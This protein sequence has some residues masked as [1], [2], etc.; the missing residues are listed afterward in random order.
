VKKPF[1]FIIRRAFLGHGIVFLL[2]ACSV[3]GLLLLNHFHDPLNAPRPSFS[4]TRLD[5]PG[6]GSQ[7]QP[8]LPDGGLSPAPTNFR[9]RMQGGKATHHSVISLVSSCA[10]RP[11]ILWLLGWVLSAWGCSRIC[12]GRPPGLGVWLLFGFDVM[13][14]EGF[15]KPFSPRMPIS[16]IFRLPR[17]FFFP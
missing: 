17:L 13:P 5:A 11:R 6:R 2:I 4:V 7:H 16:S 8:P 12:F 14:L 1:H 15:E 9:H 10:F 3:V